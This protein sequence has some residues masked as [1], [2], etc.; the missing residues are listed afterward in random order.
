MI[1]H[2]AYIFILVALFAIF[3]ILNAVL[4]ILIK[5][6][7][8]KNIEDSIK[9]IF[10]IISPLLDSAFL[11]INPDGFVSFANNHAL[12]ILKIDSKDIEKIRMSSIFASNED[13]NK[14]YS[15]ES[16]KLLKLQ[17]NLISGDKEIIPVQLSATSIKILNNHTGYILTA[18]DIHFREITNMRLELEKCRKLAEDHGKI[19]HEYV[20]KIEKLNTIIQNIF[21]VPRNDLTDIIRE[22]G[23]ELHNLF[24]SF[25]TTCWVLESDNE[26]LK[27]ISQYG[28]SDKG[29]EKLGKDFPTSDKIM[30]ALER[31]EI[32]ISDISSIPNSLRILLMQ[33]G[34]SNIVEV[35][36]SRKNTPYGLLEF[37]L[38][39]KTNAEI[40]KQLLGHISVL[41]TAICN[42]FYIK[43]SNDDEVKR[44]HEE[45]MSLE[46]R[47]LA[48][49]ENCGNELE[50]LRQ[51]QKLT[52]GRELKILELKKEINRLENAMPTLSTRQIGDKQTMQK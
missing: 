23:K 48:K 22:I 3:F 42:I 30:Q 14:I 19:H 15:L 20:K 27:L 7:L 39:D 46:K 25:M 18:D 44:L 5:R 24:G 21:N 6:R 47:L 10:P 38:K 28:L 12:K 43:I 49:I 9:T 35:P 33:E 31:K 8:K 41:L 37:Y 26:N 16:G 51:L 45:K 17:T 50:E 2:Y 1:S 40:D 36:F 29:M 34:V 11:W 52:I 13:V 4:I 32:L